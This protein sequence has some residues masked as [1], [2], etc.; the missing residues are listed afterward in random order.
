[1]SL[2][3][4]ATLLYIGNITGYTFELLV[5]NNPSLPIRAVWHKSSGST[6]GRVELYTTNGAT[7]PPNQWSHIVITHNGTEPSS[8]STNIFLNGVKLPTTQAASTW[9]PYIRENIVRIGARYDEFKG[10]VDE[11]S[12]Y[13]KDLSSSEVSDLHKHF[14]TI[15]SNEQLL[16]T[17]IEPSVPQTTS[18]Q[19]TSP[20]YS[21][22]D[23][24]PSCSSLP[25]QET[26]ELS[27]PKQVQKTATNLLN[28]TFGLLTSDHS[29][30]LTRSSLKPY[31]E[32]HIKRFAK[33]RK[34]YLMDI[35][36]ESPD[37]ALSYALSDAIIQQDAKIPSN[38]V[39]AKTTIEGTLEVM[40][41]D[42][43]ENSSAHYEFDDG[44]GTTARD[45]SANQNNGTLNNG[46]AWTE[47]KIRGALTFDGID[48]YVQVGTTTNIAPLEMRTDSFTIS[49]W[50]NSDRVCGPTWSDPTCT[51]LATRNINSVSN[52]DGYYLGIG[53]SSIFFQIGDGTSNNGDFS[54][55]YTNTNSWHHIV[56]MRDTKA[57]EF[58]LYLDGELKGT[59]QDTLGDVTNTNIFGIGRSPYGHYFK[60]KIDEVRIYKRTLSPKEISTLASAYP[61][62]GS[63]N[64]YILRTTGNKRIHLHPAV[65]PQKLYVSGMKIRIT[66]GYRL[67][68]DILFDAS[69]A[70]QLQILA[71]NQPA[72]SN[73]FIKEVY[74]DHTDWHTEIQNDAKGEQKTVVLMVNFQNTPTPTSST[75]DTINQLVFTDV[76]NFY[77]ENSYNKLTGITGNIFPSSGWY[78]IPVDKTCDS[79]KV[80]E[81]SVKK[82][83]SDVDFRQYTRLILVIPQTDGCLNGLAYIGRVSLWY[84]QDKI[85]TDSP[86]LSVNWDGTTSLYVFGHEYGHGLGLHHA[87]FVACRSS[88][89]LH[90]FDLTIAPDLCIYQQ[91]KDPYDIMG[92]SWTT[93]HMNAPHKRWLGWFGD[94]QIVTATTSATYTIEPIETATEGLKAVMLPN[95]VSVEYRKSTGFDRD[96]FGRT[97]IPPYDG[98][99][100][101][102][103][104]RDWTYSKDWEIY[105]F[106]LDVTP[107]LRVTNFR[108][109]H[110]GDPALITGTSFTDYESGVTFTTTARDADKVT[111]DVKFDTVD[112]FAQALSFSPANPSAGDLI[113]FSVNVKNQGIGNVDINTFSKLRLD[114]DNNDSWDVQAPLKFGPLASGASNTAGWPERFWAWLGNGNSTVSA[115]ST[116]T[117]I[118]TVPS[119]ANRFA[120]GSWA[121]YGGEQDVSGN[122]ENYTMKLYNGGCNT[123]ASW[124]NVW[125][126]KD[127]IVVSDLSSD[128][129]LGDRLLRKAFWGDKCNFRYT[130]STRRVEFQDTDEDVDC[131]FALFVDNQ[132]LWIASAGTH[133]AEICVD[134]TSF[135]KE[136][137]ETN[138]CKTQLFR[139]AENGVFR[140]LN[141]DGIWQGEET[142]LSGWSITL[143]KGA[144]GV[145]EDTK[146]TDSNGSV[147]F[148]NLQAGTYKICKVRQAG[149]IQTFP[150][151][152]EPPEGSLCYTR[153]LEQPGGL[154]GLSFAVMRDLVIDD[155]PPIFNALDMSVLA[156]AIK[157]DLPPDRGDMDGDGDTDSADQLVVCGA[158]WDPSDGNPPCRNYLKYNP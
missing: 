20:Q 19:S 25:P 27:N 63:V 39:E 6:T 8:T 125:T 143:D 81:E 119:D 88:P 101:H 113:S 110:S 61:I 152:T 4:S 49:A 67:D 129:I 43:F 31:F 3:S 80:L 51:I 74:A 130:A 138:N 41:A 158:L 89:S 57:K 136:T 32:E 109:I 111:V 40:H 154:T 98:A 62:E 1:M 5:T 97:D 36:R 144:D 132:P 93:W 34:P 35:M 38:C 149:W 108:Y 56:A 44:S 16:T 75:R 73:P 48:D 71:A 26:M 9:S 157:G 77:K 64:K 134:S 117:E 84:T 29:Y 92:D 151:P 107:Y 120:V 45:S 85:G 12:L 53:V 86:K 28:S 65:S 70:N 82:A 33:A 156:A 22:A 10:V 91:Y 153:T 128:F 147:K 47:G 37:E 94:S 15:S 105:P 66:N 95:G 87:N 126:V 7:L 127:C 112:L 122:Q 24:P 148:K 140:D 116:W 42:F 52:S 30:S 102:T 79:T 114:I 131:G 90:F 46:P 146:I 55:P 141:A 21:I 69:N 11:V 118:G 139:I 76:N 14:N 121:I 124:E 142:G 104:W 18:A 100:F 123:T 60:G 135:V 155:T 72:S 23:P 145:T 54:F 96:P 103:Y 83:D 137:N 50:I 99:L 68:D 133:K 106:L 13:N 78:T 17:A 150:Y 115:T 58:R 2:S 59:D